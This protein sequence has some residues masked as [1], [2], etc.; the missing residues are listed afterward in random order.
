MAQRP[1]FW[2]LLTLP[3]VTAILGWVVNRLLLFFLFGP[4]PV[5]GVWQQGLLAARSSEVAANVGGQLAR[6]LDMSELFRLMEPE[7]IA[8]YL[9]HSV[10]GRLE[11]YV[12]GIMSER[13]AV[14]WDNLPFI[15]R[16]RVYRRVRRQLPSVLDNMIDDMAENIDAIVDVRALVEEAMARDAGL[17]PAVF[18]E[19]LRPAQAFLLRAGA[20]AGFGAGLLLSLFWVFWSQPYLLPV[21]MA[22]AMILAVWLPR[23][24]LLRSRLPFGVEGQLHQQSQTVVK[25]LAHEL[26]ERVLNLRNLMQAL[27]TG[28]RAVRTRSMIRRHLRPLLDAGMVRTTIQLIL[29]ARG[30]AD[31]KQVALERTVS[32]TMG[33][34]SDAGFSHDRSGEVQQACIGHLLVV[35]SADLERLLRPVLQFRWGWQLMMVAGLG[36]LAGLEQMLWVVM[37]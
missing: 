26:S 18:K 25:V 3:L 1:D 30:Y 7:K 8:A 29:G 32:L 5:Q 10:Q 6:H 34:L 16:E 23:E 36:L 12:D 17:L 33:S 21:L 11:E 15:M 4:L 37:G 24:L 14:F 35:S 2:F 22:A 28:S 9:S 20:W 13:H 31:I 27:L 19:A